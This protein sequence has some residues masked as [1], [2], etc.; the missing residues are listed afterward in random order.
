MFS[1]QVKLIAKLES[2]MLCA[3]VGL[4]AAPG[5]SLAARPPRAASDAAAGVAAPRAVTPFTS[6]N[7]GDVYNG[8]VISQIFIIRNDGDADLQ[9]TDFVSGCA[10]AVTKSDKVIPPGKEG[11]ATLEVLT[12]SQLGGL[13]KTAT[14][15][16]NDPERPNIDFALIA[17]VLKGAPLRQGKHIGPVFVSPDTRIGMYAAAERKALAE[18]S[19][20]ADSLPVKLLRIEGGTEHL[21]P[22]VEIIEPGKRYKIVVESLPQEIGGLYTERLRVIT[23]NPTLPAFTVEVTLRVYPKQP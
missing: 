15:R 21:A 8:E 10:C 17:N 19:V 22:R 9:I 11:S 12:L 1:F 4:A 3:A 5:S 18:L 20:T 7:F 14:L 6:F 2:L 23:D 16:T 13:Y